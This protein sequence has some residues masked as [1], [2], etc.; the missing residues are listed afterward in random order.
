MS[1]VWAF[2]RYLYRW[3]YLCQMQWFAMSPSR[4]CN[5]LRDDIKCFHC[6]AYCC[7]NYSKC[8]KNL[9]LILELKKKKQQ[10][11]AEDKSNPLPEQAKQTWKKPQQS[12][13]AND[14]INFLQLAPASWLCSTP[15]KSESTPAAEKASPFP[16][17]T[18]P[19]QLNT[20]IKKLEKNL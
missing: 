12:V 6:S 16:T 1:M 14:T 11:A 18:P 15:P 5:V 10:E 9:K 8:P 20:M 19:D 4:G 13:L 3:F 2:Q 7:S 17:V